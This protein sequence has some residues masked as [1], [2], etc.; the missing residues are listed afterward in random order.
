[1]RFAPVGGLGRYGINEGVAISGQ[2]EG[3]DPGFDRGRTTS[4]VKC[5]IVSRVISGG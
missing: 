3:D 2:V 5:Y 4:F 1:M